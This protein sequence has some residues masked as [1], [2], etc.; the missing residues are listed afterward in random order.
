M[1]V[2]VF[3]FRRDDV[4]AALK[5][6]S[7]AGSWKLAEVILSCPALLGEGKAERLGKVMDVLTVQVRKTS[8]KNG[9][10]N[11]PSVGGSSFYFSDLKLLG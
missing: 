2:L 5:V 6:Y 3:F 11:L 4:E 9:K 1:L 7:R 8:R 10:K